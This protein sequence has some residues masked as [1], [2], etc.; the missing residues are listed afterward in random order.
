[1][2]EKLRG[3]NPGTRIVDGVSV[4]GELKTDPGAERSRGE[5]GDSRQAFR[6]KKKSTWIRRKTTPHRQKR[7]MDNENGISFGYGAKGIS[8][9]KSHGKENSGDARFLAEENAGS[10]HLQRRVR[11][12]EG[13]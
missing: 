6:K 4:S 2:A 1:L 13:P 9:F 12:P 8:T 5:R 7:N 10:K 3:E 11:T